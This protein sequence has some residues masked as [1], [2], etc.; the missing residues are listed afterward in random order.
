MRFSIIFPLII[1]VLFISCDTFS[2]RTPEE[3]ASNRSN[4]IPPTSH[5]IVIEN[6]TNSIDELIIEN[7]IAC[8]C[9][10]ANGGDFE[11]SFE[12][13]GDAFALYTNIFSNW[14]IDDEQQFFNLMISKLEPNTSPLLNWSN[15]EFLQFPPD[16]FIFVSDYYMQMSHIIED[17]SEE[18][19]GK[20]RLTINQ[21]TNGEWCI[22]RW[23]DLAI[24]NDTIN[25]TWSILKGEFYN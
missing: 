23:I 6:L 22:S 14:S 7:Y 25:T 21:N 10:Q 12:P 17:F 8:L 13:A 11:F 2:T 18:F 24:E 1:V 9:S 4:F 19:S 3:P 16:S 15:S 5:D 20:A